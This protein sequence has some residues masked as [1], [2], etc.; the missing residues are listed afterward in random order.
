MCDKVLPYT[1]SRLFEEYLKPLEA[2]GIEDA[3]GELRF[4][5]EEC[6]GRSTAEQYSYPEKPVSPEEWGRTEAVCKRRLLREPL[7]SIFGRQY[8][9]GR[10]FRIGGACLAPRPETE[11]LVE[12]G[13]EKLM[14]SPQDQPF[15]AAELCCG[16]GA[17]VLSLLSEAQKRGRTGLRA[18][19]GDISAEALFY[20]LKNAEALK[21]EQHVRLALCDLIPPA[22][23][24]SRF[25]LILINPPY[26]P[27]GDIPGLMPEVRDW[28]SSL[29]LD[30]GCDG[31]DFYRRIAEETGDFLKPGGWLIMEHGSGQGPLVK[32]IFRAW[33]EAG[34]LIE[35]Y[36]DLGGHDR[37]VA[38]RKS[39]N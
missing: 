14:L 39:L 35:S 13:L 21:L 28:E 4:I 1:I 34:A 5:W 6:T 37:V 12:L 3:R 36:C 15:E 30:G 24:D 17:A 8:F 16:S 32:R 19:L 25:D 11:L 26:I 20:A 33:E 31:L 22:A 7:S 9:Y 18:F 27:S 23:E 2:A 10:S 38:V 29:C